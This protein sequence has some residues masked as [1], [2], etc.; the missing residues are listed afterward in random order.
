[1][2]WQPKFGL[3]DML[4]DSWNWQKQNP[5]GFMQDCKN[6]FCHVLIMQTI[7]YLFLILKNIA[8]MFL[9]MNLDEEYL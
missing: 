5:N 1:L 2:G 8:M 6:I 4:V 9:K 3:E 7:M